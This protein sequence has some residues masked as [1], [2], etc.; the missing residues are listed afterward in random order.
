MALWPRPSTY[1]YQSYKDRYSLFFCPDLVQQTQTGRELGQP[2]ILFEHK[3]E[4]DRTSKHE[5][6]LCTA[7]GDVAIKWIFPALR[8]CVLL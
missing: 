8:G 2:Q 5:S 4:L 6:L 1:S 3:M 7:W